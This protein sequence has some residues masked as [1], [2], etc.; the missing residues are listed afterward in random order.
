VF[1]YKYELCWFDKIK[2]QD[3]NSEY[4]SGVSLGK[5]EGWVDGSDPKSM[6]FTNGQMCWNGPARSTTVQLECGPVNE[7]IEVEEP[8]TCTYV[9]KVRTPAVCEAAEDEPS[10][11]SKKEL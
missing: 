9:M 2:Q 10:E 4:D 8:S 3:L 7:I 11:D 5:W 1:R 6:R